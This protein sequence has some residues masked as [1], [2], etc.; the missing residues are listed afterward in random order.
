MRRGW[1]SL[2][3]AAVVLVVVAPAL[4]P[5]APDGYPL[6]TYPM[7]AADR[8]REVDVATAVGLD[9]DG[10]V[11][12]L[13]PETIADTDEVVLAAAT[14]WQAIG[15]GAEA[16]L[17]AEIADRVAG[18]SLAAVEVR[19]ETYDSIRYFDGEESPAEVVTHARCA[20][21]AR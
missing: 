7:F 18:G 9:G 8:G 20:V 1:Q 14:V 4:R 16:R 13:D 6:S 2:L 3:A 10:N 21:P 17:C 5:D 19:G 11:V 12:R 15:A